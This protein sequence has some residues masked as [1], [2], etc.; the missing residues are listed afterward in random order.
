MYLRC[1]RIDISQKVKDFTSYGILPDQ[2]TKYLDHL[3]ILERD[4][5]VMGVSA[6]TSNK[7]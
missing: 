4:N 6:D 1:N 2:T 3:D 7:P 5:F